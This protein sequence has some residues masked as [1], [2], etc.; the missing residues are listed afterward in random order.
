MTPRPDPR[1]LETVIT[2]KRRIARVYRR[3]GAIPWLRDVLAG[4]A[5]QSL[6]ARGWRWRW[7]RWRA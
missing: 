2:A 4:E 7:R 1:S 3:A 5:L 6:D